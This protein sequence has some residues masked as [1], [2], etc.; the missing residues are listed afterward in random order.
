MKKVLFVILALL[1]ATSCERDNCYSVFSRKYMVS[2]SCDANVSPYNLVN[3]P[4]QFISVRQNSTDGKL[5]IVD[6]NGNKYDQEL[7]D[8]QSRQFSMGLAGLIIGKPTFDNDNMSVWAYDLGCPEC[9]SRN[10]RLSFD[11]VGIATC[12]KCQGEWNL[13]SSGFPTKDSSRPLYRYPV[14]QN[15]GMITVAN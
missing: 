8:L 5:H 14:M 13:N 1:S 4:G 11:A 7:T 6:S 15:D 9:D 2:F 10:A 3:T 12:S